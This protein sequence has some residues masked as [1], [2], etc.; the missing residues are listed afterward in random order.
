MTQS[1]KSSHVRRLT[2]AALFLALALVLP[3]LTGQIPR[4]GSMLCPMHFPALLCGFVCGWPYGLAVGLIAPVLRSA[5]FGMPPMYPTAVAM[6]LELAA[7]GATA[8]IAYQRLPQKK[9]RVFAALILAMIA[10]RVVWGI[11]QFV[12]LQIQGQ[13][14]TVAMFV[15]G[16]VTSA[17]PGIALQIAIVPAIVIALERTRLTHNA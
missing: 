10:G 8:G 15:A 9:W 13:A 17:L 16:A 12:L 3:F 7:Y 4:I 1:R 5:L 11:A 2:Y 14:F 6:A